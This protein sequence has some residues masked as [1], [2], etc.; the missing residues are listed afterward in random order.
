MGITTRLV[1]RGGLAATVSCRYS[2]R[3]PTDRGNA[4]INIGCGTSVPLWTE[5]LDARAEVSESEPLAAL[6]E[7]P[8]AAFSPVTGGCTAP[9]RSS[10]AGP[11]LTDVECEVPLRFAREAPHPGARGRAP[12]RKRCQATAL[13]IDPQTPAE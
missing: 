5:R 11:L 13:H 9:H 10:P 7:S 4:A 12:R 3:Q 1:G 6:D 2:D 8:R